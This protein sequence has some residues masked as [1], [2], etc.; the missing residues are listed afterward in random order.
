MGEDCG[1]YNKSKIWPYMTSR[2]E[3]SLGSSDKE[4]VTEL[5][6]WCQEYFSS[7]IIYDSGL[8]MTLNKVK[9]LIQ[10]EQEGNR[11]LSYEREFDLIVKIEDIDE[12]A[13]RAQ[14]H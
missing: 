10:N 4:K 8:F 14:N 13:V 11:H 7:E 12:E 2:K 3:F 6:L 1:K 9:D 5:R